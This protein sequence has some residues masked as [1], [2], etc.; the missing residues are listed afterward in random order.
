MPEEQTI[1]FLCLGHFPEVWH[2]PFKAASYLCM[3]FCATFC[4]YLPPVVLVANGRRDP[5]H[6]LHLFLY[7]GSL[8]SQIP[9]NRNSQ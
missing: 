3:P 9:I 4:V 7:L 8:I 5:F 1:L 6:D 2:S